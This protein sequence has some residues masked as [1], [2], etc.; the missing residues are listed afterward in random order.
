MGLRVG[1]LR[2]G[3]S[4]LSLQVDGLNLLNAQ[5]AILDPTLLVVD[6]ESGLSPDG[7]ATSPTLLPS[8]GFGGVLHDLQDGQMVRIG[9]RWGGP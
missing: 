8:S 9:L 4:V 7:T 1:L 5:H 2:L 6:P 3:G